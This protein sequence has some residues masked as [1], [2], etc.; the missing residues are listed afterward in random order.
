MN[1]EPFGEASQTA[2][3]TVG[4][5][6]GRAGVTVRTLHH[7]DRIGLVQ[8]SERTPAGHRRY[9]APDIA[10]LYR[11]LA[12]RHLGLSLSHID[13]LLHSDAAQPLLTTVRQQLAH[14]DDQLH[15][16]GRLRKRLDRLAC[17]LTR[18]PAA[19]TDFTPD[20]MEAIDMTVNLTRIYTRTGDDGHTHLGDGSRVD[21]TSPRIEALGDIDELN[22]Q[23][24]VALAGAAVPDPYAEW[25]RRIQNELFDVG[26]DLCMPA[27]DDRDRLRLDQEYVERL[28]A[29]CDIANEPLEPLRSFVIPGGSPAT[30]QLHLCRT[31]CRR[32]ERRALAVDQ[33]NPH[34]TRYLNRLSD[35]LFILARAVDSRPSTLWEPATSQA[36]G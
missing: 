31:V 27:T 14:V 32:A 24:G 4:E 19:A 21:K 18:N 13:Q 25:L 1:T 6:A 15:D 26:A 5:L 33:H 10:L 36:V 12:L 11:V 17:A 3:W 22:A 34:V 7:Y 8:P 20:L 30:A 23:I 29:H 9:S 35:L 28:E 2:V 16:L